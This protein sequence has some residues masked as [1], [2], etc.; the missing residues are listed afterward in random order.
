MEDFLRTL[1]LSKLKRE[2]EKCP[3]VLYNRLP[4]CGSRSVA[5]TL[6]TSGVSH[7]VNLVT[8]VVEHDGHSTMTVKQQAS[9]TTLTLLYRNVFVNNAVEF[10]C[11]S[12][13]IVKAIVNVLH[14]LSVS[15]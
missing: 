15:H 13:L 9:I 10:V 12:T 8:P 11:I 5:T 7:S 14:F 1:D 6:L 4:K 2:I 3:R